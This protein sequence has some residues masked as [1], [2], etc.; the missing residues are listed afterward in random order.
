MLGVAAATVLPSEVWPFRKI[1]LPSYPEFGPLPDSV[2]KNTPLYFDSIAGI[3]YMAPPLEDY[4]RWLG[5]SR[6]AYPGRL[7]N[8]GQFR[9]TKISSPKKTIYMEY[10]R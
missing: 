9:I 4:G 5:L 3:A 8:R 1:F 2:F 6:S 7:A 10:T